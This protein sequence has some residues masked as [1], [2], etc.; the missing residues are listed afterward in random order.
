[1]LSPLGLDHSVNE[2]TTGCSH[3]LFGLAANERTVYQEV[4][5]WR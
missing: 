4:V 2:G 3:E 5:L 1:M